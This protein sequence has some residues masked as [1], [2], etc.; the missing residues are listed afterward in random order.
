M[1]TGEIHIRAI[2]RVSTEDT[3]IPPKTPES[4]TEDTENTE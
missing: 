2:P 4:S 1:T 3:E